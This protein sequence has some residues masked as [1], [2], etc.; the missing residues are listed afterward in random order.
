M[1][2]IAAKVTDKEITIAADSIV[3]KGTLKRTN[4]AKLH[5]INNM[6]A[7]GC[8]NAE[9]LS[10]FFEYLA[11]H[12]PESA[13]KKQVRRF[14]QRFSEYKSDYT[15]EPDIENCYLIVFEGHLFETDGMFV[16]EITNYTAIGE[17]EAYALAALHLGHSCVE[18]VKTSCDLCCFTSE[19]I[20]HYYIKKE[21][22]NE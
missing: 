22:T 17:G 16:Q 10:I 2:V 1:S 11:E 15:N 14:L 8:G 19:P 6:I 9:E 7:G 3:T 20:I 21:G 13:T 18:A 12:K 4:F 5:K